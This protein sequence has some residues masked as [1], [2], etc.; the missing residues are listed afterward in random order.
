[1]NSCS[2]MTVHE[3]MDG[4]SIQMGHVYLAPGGQHLLVERDGERY[5]CRLS[6][7]HP[8]NHHRPSVDVLLHSV[9]Q[10][11]GANAIGVMLTGA[12]S[13]GVMG[14]KALRDTG[15]ATVAQD[16]H[17]SVVWGMAGSA[18]K[19]GAAGQIL[20]LEQIAAALLTLAAHGREGRAARA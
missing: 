1:M 18:V 4:Q 20:P 17:S 13:D 5:R 16:E 11:V 12:G 8:V 6:D 7:A 15:A 10:E 3:A 2:L 14:L 9:A 19:A